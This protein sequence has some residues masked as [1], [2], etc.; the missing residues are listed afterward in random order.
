[1]SGILCLEGNHILRSPSLQGVVQT[2]D[3]VVS[4]PHL[5][6]AKLSRAQFIISAKTF[7]TLVLLSYLGV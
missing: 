1:M 2:V 7:I 5:K 6:E 4:Q 3:L